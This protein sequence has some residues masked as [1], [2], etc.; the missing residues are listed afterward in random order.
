MLAE[1]DAS[2][3]V[4]PQSVAAL[5]MLPTAAYFS[6]G[7]S[8]TL[9]PS[10]TGLYARGEEIPWETFPALAERNGRTPPGPP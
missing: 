6:D 4:H 5:S 9:D 7:A 1:M 3:R 2:G 8:C 10:S